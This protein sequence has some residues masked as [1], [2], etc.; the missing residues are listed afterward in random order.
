MI[1]FRLLTSEADG[2]KFKNLHNILFK[3]TAANVAW[4][5]WYFDDIGGSYTR[6]YGAFDGANL[7][8]C[9]CVEPKK[10]SLP[11]VDSVVIK[12]ADGNVKAPAPN[13]IDVGRC[14][15]VGIHPDYQRRG[16]FIKLSEYAIEQ[17][18]LLGEYQHILGFPQV[19]KAVI[20]GHLKAGWTFVH[21]IEM[22]SYKPD[23]LPSYNISLG[24]V[25]RV[26]SFRSLKESIPPFVTGF[27][28]DSTY[29]DKR[30]LKHPDNH[31]IVL[32][33]DDA[34]I[35][36]KPYGHACHILDMN[37]SADGTGLV[38]V[39]RAAKTLAARHKWAELTTWCSSDE[40]F[41]LELRAMGFKSGAQFG[42]SVQLLAVRIA[43]QKQLC[44]QGPLHFMT[45]VEEI[46]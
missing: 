8:G 21:D 35:V 13:I 34:Y 24:S 39:I 46:Y 40:I 28:E 16:L 7:V 12:D 23:G 32:S 44:I 33:K 41:S 45:G 30:W 29:R 6:V 25:D 3:N 27:V 22:L 42:L 10:L 38:N 2:V 26:R 20:G 31:Y 4:F 11:L 14:F 17:E 9:W 19:G 18:R 5:R 15:A 36:L 37:G 43:A 1:S